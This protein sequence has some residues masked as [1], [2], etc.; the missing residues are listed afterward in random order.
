MRKALLVLAAAALLA[1]AALADDLN[2][3]PWRGDPGSTFQHWQFNSEPEDLSQIPPDLV[4]NQFGGP[5]ILDEYSGDSEWLETHAGREG[6]WHAYW[7]F[8]IDLPNDPE[9]RPLKDIYVQFTYYYDDPTG[10]DNGRPL[11]S[12]YWPDGDN[13]VELVDEYELGTGTN[14]YYSRWH[15]QIMPNPSFETLYVIADDEYSELYFDQIVVDTIC[16]PEPAT[17]GLFALAG[18]ALLRKR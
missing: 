6:V 1:P 5:L 9:P 8:Y 4:D 12:V 3:P 13:T 17:F 18:L 10:W 15:I 11:P 14:W 7:D 2:Q 16:I